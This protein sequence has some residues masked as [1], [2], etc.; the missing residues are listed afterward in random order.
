[1]NIISPWMD[2]NE[3]IQGEYFAIRMSNVF[4]FFCIRQNKR[5]T[6]TVNILLRQAM[7]RNQHNEKHPIIII[8]LEFVFD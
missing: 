4:F 2:M 1:V 5:G 3:N 6:E 7:M 8:N